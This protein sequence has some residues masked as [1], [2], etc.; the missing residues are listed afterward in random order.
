MPTTTASP[1]AHLPEPPYYVVI[2]SSRRT[3]GDN[4]YGNMAETMARLASEQPGY[5]GVESVRDADGFGITNSYWAD[6][7]AFSMEGRGFPRRRTEVR[8][9]ALVRGISGRV[10][11][12]ERAYGFAG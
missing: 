9:R 5:L 6:R 7:E 3:E 8:T 10:A 11:R 1:F 12:V 4:G 2:F